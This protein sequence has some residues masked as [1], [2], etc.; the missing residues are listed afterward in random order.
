M[1][2]HPGERLLHDYIDGELDGR[3]A[4]AVAAHLAACADCSAEAVRLRDLL[5]RAAL[6]EPSIAPGRDLWPAIEAGIDSNRELSFDGYAG[7][8]G[9]GRSLW[10]HRYPLAA[11][12]SLLVLVASTGTLLLVRDS[13][14]AQ[15]VASAA[16]TERTAT[17]VQLV[18]VPGQA[19]YV[20]AIQELDGLL[21]ERA[22]QLDP[23]TAAVVERN[24]AII[25]QAI[26][27]TQRALAADPA[28]GEL[29]R[30]VSTAYKTKINLLRRAVELPART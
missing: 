27:E 8:R 23:Q 1:T 13:G 22:G 6:L 30:A 5:D 7:R 17:P 20:S 18:S 4:E 9:A 21:R 3:A 12:A 2:R 11:A 26:R 24:M 19:D 14:P 10:R 28:N 29:N 15:P 25:D 16:S